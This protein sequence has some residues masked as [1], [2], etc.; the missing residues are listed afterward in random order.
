M[1][2]FKMLYFRSFKCQYTEQNYWDGV[3]VHDHAGHTSSL[4]PR[5]RTHQ[6]APSCLTCW[7]HLTDLKARQAGTRSRRPAPTGRTCRGTPPGSTWGR[8]TS[9]RHGEPGSSSRMWKPD[10]SWNASHRHF[11]HTHP[12]TTPRYYQTYH[13]CLNR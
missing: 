10:Y 6:A 13:K 9:C 5:R 11:Y 1:G 4:A 12:G 3:L 7:A 8:R 2:S